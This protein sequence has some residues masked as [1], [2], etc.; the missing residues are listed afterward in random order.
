MRPPSR[1]GPITPD[2]RKAVIANSVLKD[3]YEKTIDR[4]SA[5]ELLAGRAV[6]ATAPA[7]TAQAGGGIFDSVKGSLEGLMRDGGRKDGLVEAAAKS[8]AR[9]VGSSI[10]REIVRGVLGSLLGRRR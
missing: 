10:G 5:Y 8:A 7:A 3:T 6:A 4:E 2:E 1:I 9:T